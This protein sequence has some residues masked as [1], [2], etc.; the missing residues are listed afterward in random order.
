MKRRPQA[1]FGSLDSLL[2]TMTNVVGILVIILVVTILGVQEAVSRISKQLEGADMI[3]QVQYD[4]A[5]D[6]TEQLAD[7]LAKLQAR[8]APDTDLKD[9]RAQLAALNQEI[10]QL[11]AKFGDAPE[12]TADPAKLTQ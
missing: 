9:E 6:E 5:V 8:P 7:E 3:T 11:A 12:A 4:T 2:D 1:S 10:K